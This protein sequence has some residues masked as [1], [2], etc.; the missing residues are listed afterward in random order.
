MLP[1]FQSRS[2][3]LPT[4]SGQLTI[5]EPRYLQM[6][7]KLKNTCDA[8]LSGRGARFLHILSKEAAPPAM[9][10]DDS[11]RL[12][13]LPQVGCCALVENISPG[14]G[15]TLIVHYVGD[16]RVSLHFVE[17]PS[18]ESVPTAAGEWFDDFQAD[19]L[20]PDAAAA[21]N[22]AEQDVAAVV[23]LIQ[24]LSRQV[25]PENSAIPEAIPQHA[26]PAPGSARRTSYDALKESGHRAATA[27]DIWRR[28]GSV[29]GSQ[30][31]PR[32][33]YADPYTEVAE[34]LGKA[35]RQELFSFAVSQLLQLGTAERA[36]L[37]LSQDTAGRLQYV[38]EA[39]RP[40]LA[41]LSAKASL[42]A[43]LEPGSS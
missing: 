28:H 14:P 3:L 17:T 19:T 4:A 10:G 21:I 24:K 18:D 26:P 43:A 38:L 41:D 8:G 13:G 40:F 25:D 23:R 2:V 7:T 16:R 15:G 39:A 9:L 6:F 34:L 33:I 22:A 5:Y 35:R 36:A 12:A 30:R 31:S 1:V 27:I 29:Y 37:L 11:A 42:K 20:E 32:N